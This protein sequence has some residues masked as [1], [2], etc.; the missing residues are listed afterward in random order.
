MK[1]VTDENG[2][3]YIDESDDDLM[4]K[5]AKTARDTPVATYEE[6][7]QRVADEK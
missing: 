2:N 4:D 6:A 7:L 1:V 5:L 3:K